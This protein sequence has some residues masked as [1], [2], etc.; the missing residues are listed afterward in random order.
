MR[1]DG[2]LDW[3]GSS[4]QH[5]SKNLMVYLL[6]SGLNGSVVSP[7]VTSCGL[8]GLDPGASI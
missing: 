7:A 5:L 3:W 2:G 6:Q 1:D 4:G 8:Q